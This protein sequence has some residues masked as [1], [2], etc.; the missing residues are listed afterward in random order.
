MVGTSRNE[1]IQTSN[2][3]GRIVSPPAVPPYNINSLQS[4]RNL[5]TPRSSFIPN[6]QIHTYPNTLPALTRPTPSPKSQEHL[7]IH[8]PVNPLQNTKITTPIQTNSAEALRLN[9][10]SEVVKPIHDN[11]GRLKVE[12]ELSIVSPAM[13]I[14]NLQEGSGNPANEAVL[15]TMGNARPTVVNVNP[16]VGM[17]H[18][19]IYPGIPITPNVNL[20]TLNISPIIKNVKPTVGNTNQIN[21]ATENVNPSV[22]NAN[23]RMGT[24]EPVRGNVHPTTGN[25][26]STI[27]N[28]NPTL[29]NNNPSVGT[30]NPTMRNADLITEN[31]NPAFEIVS[32][33]MEKTN[34]AIGTVNP[35][36][37]TI[38]LTMGNG[39]PI[40]GN[41]NL[42][43]ANASIAMGDEKHTIGKAIPIPNNGSP[44]KG[45]D[46]QV[47]GV[48]KTTVMA[49][50]GRIAEVQG[51]HRC[52]VTKRGGR[53]GIAL[54]EACFLWL[55]NGMVI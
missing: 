47:T 21:P 43:V 12:H 37:G 14:V 48:V 17:V 40:M 32:P 18:P 30:V 2:Q 10:S 4:A 45:N 1:P 3:P 16:I 38:N 22:E 35:T 53:G 27:V 9:P 42:N 20:E 28:V 25:V 15:Q 51:R 46:N 41:V 31:V 5:S 6:L 23:P 29:K 39:N 33:S 34:S 36:I 24:V 26:D 13:G 19:A 49:T 50:N 55:A 44:T 54:Q 52:K 11:S 7:L 8:E